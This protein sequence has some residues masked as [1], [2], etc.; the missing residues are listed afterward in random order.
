MYSAHLDDFPYSLTA[1]IYFP[2]PKMPL[3]LAASHAS[4]LSLKPFL[5]AA[6]ADSATVNFEANFDNGLPGMI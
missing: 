5:S 4:I 3:I 2:L 1:S 6:V